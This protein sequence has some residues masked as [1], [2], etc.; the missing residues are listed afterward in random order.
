MCG[1]ASVGYWWLHVCTDIYV[2]VHMYVSLDRCSFRYAHWE[3]KWCRMIENWS[4]LRTVKS[5]NHLCCTMLFGFIPPYCLI[6]HQDHNKCDKY[7]LLMSH[8][9]YWPPLTSQQLEYNPQKVLSVCPKPTYVGIMQVLFSDI[10]LFQKPRQ[11]YKT[12][13]ETTSEPLCK[14]YS[15]I[16]LLECINH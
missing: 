16:R 2:W 14:Q 15:S 9:T 6:I 3:L 1:H 11:L 4:S 12:S 7:A 8:L 10:D 5:T 13:K